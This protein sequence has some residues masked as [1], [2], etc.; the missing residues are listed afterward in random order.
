MKMGMEESLYDRLG[1]ERTI[2]AI[3]NEFNGLLLADKRLQNYFI[4][5][6]LGA[7]KHHQIT[8]LV[9]L[10]LGGPNRYRGQNLRTAHAGL[11][12][13]SNEYDIAITHFKTALK[14][15]NTPIEGMAKVEALLRSVKPHII[16]K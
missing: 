8:L 9:S 1:G 14:K 4:N 2:A 11:N 15:F 13:T 10:L 3:V 7:L 5:V 6:E 16:N 12:I